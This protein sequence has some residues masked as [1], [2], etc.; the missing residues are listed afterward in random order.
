MKFEEG[1]IF[2]IV[3]TMREEA[4]SR[5]LAP[6]ANVYETENEWII[7]LIMPGIEKDSLKVVLEDE[8][9]KVEAKKEK[10]EELA[11]CHHCYEWPY[12]EYR[13]IIELPKEIES[14]QI[15]TSYRN[16]ILKIRIPKR[17]KKIIEIEVKEE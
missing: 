5:F 17:I 16:G 6:P 2:Q 14:S 3:R 1:F 13:R 11:M 15:S 12:S 10:S 8:I 9:L 4:P 7:E